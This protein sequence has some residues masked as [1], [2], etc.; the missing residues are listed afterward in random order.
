[1]ENKL[2]YY[3]LKNFEVYD[4]DTLRNVSI[5]LGFS[6]FYN[7]NIRLSDIDCPEINTTNIKE[8]ELAIDAKLYT[9][10][11]LK[12]NLI[13]LH[14]IYLDKYGRILGDIYNEYGE[15]LQEKLLENGLA[16]S[17][18]G[19]SKVDWNELLNDPNYI[20]GERIILPSLKVNLNESSVEELCLL[21]GVG[22]VTAEEIIKNRPFSK[23]EELILVNG[24]GKVTLNK[25]LEQNIAYV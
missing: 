4:G 8:Y 13:Y 23:I 1:M 22:T 21:N 12:S 16:V 9:E 15:L 18:N 10:N 5:D 11:F 24:I 2:Y 19:G 14:S 25:I 3:K 7:N 20:K 17:Y 6:I